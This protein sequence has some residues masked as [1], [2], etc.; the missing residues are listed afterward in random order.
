MENYA[1]YQRH[2]Y[3]NQVVV[4]LRNIAKRSAYED[5]YTNDSLR[6]DLIELYNNYQTIRENAYFEPLDE[7]QKK[8][9]SGL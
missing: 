2:P 5:Q 9:V 8:I 4:N 6:T 3:L 1:I 7:F